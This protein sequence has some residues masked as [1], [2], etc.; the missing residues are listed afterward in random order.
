M[1]KYSKGAGKSV[2]SAMRRKKSGSL[3]SGSGKKV[4]IPADLT[5][6]SS[7][8]NDTWYFRNVYPKEPHANSVDTILLRNGGKSI[9]DQQVMERSKKE[10]LTRIITQRKSNDDAIEKIFR[11]TYTIGPGLFSIRKEEQKP[12]D[13]AFIQRHIYE[14]SR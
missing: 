5:V 8:S 1:A 7:H 11:Y 6:E 13:T 9:N 2:K 10:G 3:R 14:Y 12:G 4:T